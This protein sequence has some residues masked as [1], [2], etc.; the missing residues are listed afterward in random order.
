M[1][2]EAINII[3]NEGFDQKVL[4]FFIFSFCLTFCLSCLQHFEG[5]LRFQGQEAAGSR[6]AQVPAMGV[7]S[8]D[9]AEG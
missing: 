4:L 6:L 1:A 7:Y 3:R 9:R 2:S 8:K 5:R